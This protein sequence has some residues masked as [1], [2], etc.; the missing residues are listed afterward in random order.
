MPPFLKTTWNR[1]LGI[2]FSPLHGKGSADLSDCY[3]TGMRRG[4][5][6]TKLLPQK[7]AENASAKSRNQQSSQRRSS[8]YSTVCETHIRCS[9]NPTVRSRTGTPDNRFEK[10]KPFLKARQP[11]EPLFYSVAQFGQ[12]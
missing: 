9:G 6:I 8:G 7:T 3:T 12:T 10:D 1:W 11:T 5:E 4:K 2:L